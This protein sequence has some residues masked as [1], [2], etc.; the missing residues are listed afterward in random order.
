MFP[1]AEN[2][3]DLVDQARNIFVGGGRGNNLV[4]DVSPGLPPVM[5]DRMRIVQVI[6]NLLDNASRHSPSG[7]NITVAVRRSAYEVTISV[8]DQGRGILA[9]RL[10][11]LFMKFARDDADQGNAGVGG[12]GLGL[13]ICK[14]IVEAHGGRIWA[15]SDGLNLGAR[16]TFTLPVSQEAAAA[17][18]SGSAISPTALAEAGPRPARVLARGRV[19]T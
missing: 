8:S 6:G 16:F 3:G 2:A 7:S 18:S 9:D 1:G 13:A 10:P 19:S 17:E 15:E 12:A 4:F 5:A 11:R 14:G